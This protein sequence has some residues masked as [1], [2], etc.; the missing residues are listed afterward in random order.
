MAAGEAPGE[1]ITFDVCVRTPYVFNTAMAHFLMMAAEASLFLPGNPSL[2][3]E[4]TLGAPP[5]IHLDDGH[6]L[7]ETIFRE[8][9]WGET[10]HQAGTFM[11][12]KVLNGEFYKL[13]DS[14]MP[15]SSPPPALHGQMRDALEVIARL[16]MTFSEE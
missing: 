10:L 15:T 11:A 5:V 4:V 7:F 6:S 16:S 2:Q 12:R 1:E 14:P 9:S 13:R 3:V 8:G